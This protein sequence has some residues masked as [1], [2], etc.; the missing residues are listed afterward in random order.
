MLNNSI[1]CFQFHLS[2]IRKSSPTDFFTPAFTQN[3]LGTLFGEEIFTIRCIN[4]C[5]AIAIAMFKM[6]NIAFSRLGTHDVEIFFGK[7]KLLSHFNYTFEN[8]IRAT[9][10]KIILNQINNKF[11][12]FNINL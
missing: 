12:I 4:T 2:N 5:V 3:G 10:N 8:A 11:H 7:I 6:K 9:V 1:K